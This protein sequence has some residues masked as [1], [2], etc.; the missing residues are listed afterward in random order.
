LVGVGGGVEGVSTLMRREERE[1]RRGQVSR[2][3]F[4][5]GAFSFREGE[6]RRRERT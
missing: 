3:R 4:E 5:R 2:F 6:E 1:S